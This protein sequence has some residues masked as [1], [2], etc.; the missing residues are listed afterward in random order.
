MTLYLMSVTRLLSYTFNHPMTLT[1]D[2]CA[3]GLVEY[4]LS[5][6]D[7]PYEKSKETM[8]CVM[9]VGCWFPYYVTDLIQNEVIKSNLYDSKAM[10]NKAVT[11]CKDASLK[12]NLFTGHHMWCKNQQRAIQRIDEKMKIVQNIQMAK[13]SLHAWLLILKWN[14]NHYI[15]TWNY[16][17]TL[18]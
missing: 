12:F 7:S 17:R 11:V 4:G 5:T 8:K 15:Y 14:L 10:A 6:I 18:W 9:Y 1:D 13:V 2:C 3:H 16:F